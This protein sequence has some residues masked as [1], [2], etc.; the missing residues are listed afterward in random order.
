M[1]SN[2]RFSA[3]MESFLKPRPMRWHTINIKQEATM[4]PR[5][6]SSM[7]MQWRELNPHDPLKAGLALQALA[8]AAVWVGVL[9]GV[10]AFCR[11]ALNL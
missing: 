7:R 3:A 8:S 2:D 4:I 10:F 6:W 1:T 5:S 9:V 11:W